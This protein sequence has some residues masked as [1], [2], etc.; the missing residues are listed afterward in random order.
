MVREDEAYCL[1]GG[2]GTY[3]KR[4]ARKAVERLIEYKWLGV[5]G[6]SMWLENMIRSEIFKRFAFSD[7]R[8]EMTS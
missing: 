8:P 2:G 5:R 4:R 7:F 1:S 3:C 6:I